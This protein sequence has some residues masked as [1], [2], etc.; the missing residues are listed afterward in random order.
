MG[1]FRPSWAGEFLLG[2]GVAFGAE[3]GQILIVEKDG[4]KLRADP[5]LL[6]GAETA[7]AVNGL[8]FIGNWMGV[9]TRS[10][11]IFADLPRQEV[12]RAHYGGHGVIVGPDG[13]FVA[14]LGAAG[15]LF[16][17]P[18]EGADLPVTIR[19]PRSSDLYF[20]RVTS[21]AGQNGQHVVVAATRR[22]GIAA[23]PFDSTERGLHTL[24]FESFDAIDVCPLDKLSLAV[25]A[26][27][28]DGTI[29]MCR[30]VIGETPRTQTSDAVKFPDIRGTAYRILNSGGSLVVFT[31]QAT[32]FLR[33]MA[34][35]FLQGDFSNGKTSRVTTLA[36]PIKAIDANIVDE[37]WLMI[38]TSRRVLTMDLRKFDWGRQRGSGR[39]EQAGQPITFSPAWHVHDDQ[40]VGV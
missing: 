9:S 30:D 15:L 38:I 11:V 25:A 32:Y 33:D 3:D 22:D 5:P 18:M 16:F 19:R 37:D 29:V 36:F 40:L 6:P 31:S 34:A 7:E 17:K 26:L 14:P 4:R 13:H 21:L 23:M 8:A 12:V 2:Q 35:R 10:D 1:D 20:Y 27:G 39:E 28:K 24:T